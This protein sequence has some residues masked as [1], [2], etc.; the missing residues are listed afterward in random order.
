MP[1]IPTRIHGILDYLVGVIL[2][3]APWIFGFADEGA[4]MWVPVVIGA[5]LIVY[6]L[7]TDYELG[8][9]R[10]IPMSVHLMIDVVAGIVLAASPWLFQFSDEVWIPHV[11]VGILAIGTGL[12]TER[13][14]GRA[15]TR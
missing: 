1:I 13:R 4:A 10:I 14:P 2:I 11:V 9:V 6:A 15:I 7:L 8:V 12:L 5:G 3:A